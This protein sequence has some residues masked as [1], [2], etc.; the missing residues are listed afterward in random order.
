MSA[1]HVGAKIAW[2]PLMQFIALSA[3]TKRS[4]KSPPVASAI[5]GGG[6]QRGPALD[7]QL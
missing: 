4:A 3:G 7:C 5:N 6:E 1:T 2:H